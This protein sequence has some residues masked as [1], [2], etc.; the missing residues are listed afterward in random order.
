VAWEEMG[1]RPI[2]QLASLQIDGKRWQYAQQLSKLSMRAA[3]ADWHAVR[4]AW[5]LKQG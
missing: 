3:V 5:E 4:R 1:N 2:E